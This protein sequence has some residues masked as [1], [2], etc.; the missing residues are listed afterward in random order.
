MNWRPHSP[1]K[2]SSEQAA[3]FVN[4]AGS[5][6]A[7]QFNIS[8]TIVWFL[9]NEPGFLPESTTSINWAGPRRVFEA[10][11]NEATKLE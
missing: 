11:L 9:V 2:S 6:G 4:D 5:V 3:V 10:F 1:G 7:H 8:F